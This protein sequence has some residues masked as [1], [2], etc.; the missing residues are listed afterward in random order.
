MFDFHSAIYVPNMTTENAILMTDTE[1]GTSGELMVVT[2]GR[3]TKCGPT[4]TPYCILNATTAAG[5]SVKTDYLKIRKDVRYKCDVTGTGTP[6]IGV[7]T[8]AIS[9]DGLSIDAANLTTGKVEIVS[10]NAAKQKAIVIF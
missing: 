7:M 8:A 4:A 3:L 6:T 2:A 9:S 10:Y 5:T 1:A